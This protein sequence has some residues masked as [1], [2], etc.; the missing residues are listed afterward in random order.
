MGGKLYC[1]VGSGKRG[2]F[3]ESCAAAIN[4]KREVW[5]ERKHGGLVVLGAGRGICIGSSRTP[6]VELGPRSCQATGETF[7]RSLPGRGSTPLCYLLGFVQLAMG[8]ANP[9][10]VEIMQSHLFRKSIL[11]AQ[12]VSSEMVQMVNCWRAVPSAR[13]RTV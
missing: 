9:T 4:E 3:G 8:C 10:L 13:F 1:D 12:L 2:F 5:E 6:Q 11:V 7:L